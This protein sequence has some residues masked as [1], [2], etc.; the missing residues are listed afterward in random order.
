MAAVAA[1]VVVG[2]AGCGGGGGKPAPAATT[3]VGASAPVMSV[4]A[5][6]AEYQGLMGPGCA[7][8]DECQTLVTARLH[9]AHDLRDAMKAEDP[10]GY[11]VPI[12]DVNRAD[13][14]ARDYG[15]ENLGAAGNMMAVLQPIQAA[16][17]WYASNR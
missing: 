10:S 6:Y 14:V 13:R 15:T 11:A 2:V 3:S 1:A 17:T 4:E 8:V 9:A 12:A 5:A 16:I 7:T